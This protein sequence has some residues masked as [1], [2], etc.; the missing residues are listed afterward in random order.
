MNGHIYLNWANIPLSE[1]RVLISASLRFFLA[2]N[3]RV[4]KSSTFWRFDRWTVI[5]F[6]Q[7]LKGKFIIYS[8]STVSSVSI[9]GEQIYGRRHADV[10]EVSSQ[11]TI[12]YFW[13]GGPFIQNAHTIERYKLIV[14]FNLTVNERCVR[15]LRDRANF[16]R[17]FCGAFQ[18]VYL[19]IDT[20][21]RYISG[22]AE[23]IELETSNLEI[24]I[25][26]K[27]QLGS[28]N[29][30]TLDIWPTPSRAIFHIGRSAGSDDPICRQIPSSRGACFIS[31]PFIPLAMSVPIKI[32]TRH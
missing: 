6:L 13:G 26:F 32:P 3:E 22:L 10:H 27:C 2:S 12:E 7:D 29:I 16:I 1:R 23:G 5:S 21:Q 18:K 4:S 20:I 25:Y 15:K 28:K 31:T 11:Y 9:R 24:E 17:F 14:Q 19:V 8:E 30:F